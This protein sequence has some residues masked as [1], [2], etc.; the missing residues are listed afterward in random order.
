[1]DIFIMIINSFLFISSV[2][3]AFW[4]ECQI[5][6]FKHRISKE[7][8]EIKEF[9]IDTTNKLYDLDYEMKKIPFKLKNEL[10]IFLKNSQS[11]GR[12]W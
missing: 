6:D 11:N 9:Y 2:I 5:E 12:R 3:F 7:Q 4:C 10:A 8:E 1:M